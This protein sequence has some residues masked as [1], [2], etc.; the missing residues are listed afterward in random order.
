MIKHLRP[1][2]ANRFAFQVSPS[3]G[4]GPG[5]TPRK[6]ASLLVQWTI[7]VGI[8]HLDL[9][10]FAAIFRS[11]CFVAAFATVPFAAVLLFARG[12]LVRSRV[13]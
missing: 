8:A 11:F 4:N 13:G 1:L 9:F 2:Q 7:G 3:V 5:F 12:A 10:A 6:V